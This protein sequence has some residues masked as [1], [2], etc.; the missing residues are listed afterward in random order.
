M[1]P[2]KTPGTTSALPMQNP[3]ANT[4]REPCRDRL[5]AKGC[6]GVGLDFRERSINKSLSVMTH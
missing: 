3:R 4:Q 6:A 5:L 1:V 2:P